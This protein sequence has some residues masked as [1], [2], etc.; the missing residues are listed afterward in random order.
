M[1]LTILLRQ[2]RGDLNKMVAN[3]SKYNT[4]ATSGGVVGSPTTFPPPNSRF[5]TFRILILGGYGNVGKYIVKLLLQYGPPHIEIVVAG[6]RLTK[7][8]EFLE[9]LKADFPSSSWT[10]ISTMFVDASDS[11]SLSKALDGQSADEDCT[12]SDD[13]WIR[14]AGRIDMVL[15]ASSTAKYTRQVVEAILDTPHVVDYLDVVYS[16]EKV[17]IL[18]ELAHAIEESGRCF[19]TDGGFHPGLPAALI[20]AILQGNYEVV[21]ESVASAERASFRPSMA[22]DRSRIPAFAT[23]E[24]VVVGS[25]IRLDWNALHAELGLETM[26]EFAGEFQNMNATHYQNGMWKTLSNTEM[27]TTIP[28]AMDFSS[29]AT[30]ADQP[31]SPIPSFGTQCTIPMFLEELRDLPTLIDKEFQGG[32]VNSNEGCDKLN[33]QLSD[34]GFYVGG[35]NWAVDWIITPCV[36]LTMSLFPNSVAVKQ[37]MGRFLFWGLLTFSSPPYGCLLQV[38]AKGT[39]AAEDASTAANLRLEK[40]L[41]VYHADG[42]FLTA[43]PVVATLLQY[44]SEDTSESSEQSEVANANSRSIRKAGLWYQ[45]AIVD[46]M[47][48]LADMHKMGVTLEVQHRFG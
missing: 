7:A 42:Y 25:V 34:L 3:T 6:R 24:S 48:L 36:M 5:P 35:L 4:T 23:V 32:A 21:N 12:K 37:W 28:R 39:S 15:V 43:A 14:R 27:F 17:E 44:L 41:R 8:N 45:G 30:T 19:I 31:D 46:P 26:E 38:E 40:V 16:Q 9:E 10:R 2:R 29:C 47:K 22:M 20:R 1:E 33:Q 11:E 18:N 13:N